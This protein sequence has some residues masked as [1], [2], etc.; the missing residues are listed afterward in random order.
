MY[1][2]TNVTNSLNITEEIDVFSFECYNTNYYQFFPLWDNV[3]LYIYAFVPFILLIICNLLI[4]YKIFAVNVSVTTE[5]QQR[6][7][8]LTFTILFISIL[9]ICF[10]LPEIICFSYFFA[11]LSSTNLGTLALYSVDL[12]HFTFNSFMFWIYYETNSVFRRE[13]AI[14]LINF[15][16]IIKLNFYKCFYKIGCV[17]TATLSKKIEDIN[18]NKNRFYRSENK[19]SITNS[20]QQPTQRTLERIQPRLEASKF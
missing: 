20:L 1:T 8:K 4:V 5:A 15:F 10:V 7:R 13:C 6:K 12:I 14:C 17:A 11:K 16:Y 19:R 18:R 3:H 2:K 9:F